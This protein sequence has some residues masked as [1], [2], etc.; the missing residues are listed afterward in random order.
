MFVIA[1]VISIGIVSG[2]IYFFIGLKNKYRIVEHIHMTYDGKVNSQY[3]VQR[4]HSFFGIEWWTQA[5]SGGEWDN[6]SIYSTKKE[7]ETYIKAR[8]FN[9]NNYTKIHEY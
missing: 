4:L 8:S 2:I 9:S 7:A 1:L 6:G 5:D 3:I